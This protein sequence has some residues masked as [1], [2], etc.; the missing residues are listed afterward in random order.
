MKP[1]ELLSDF[2]FGP[3]DVR[4]NL[5]SARMLFQYLADNLYSAD[6]ASGDRVASSDVTTV[7]TWLHELSEAAREMSRNPPGTE[8]QLLQELRTCRRVIKSVEDT[9]PRCGHVH[10]GSS[11]CGMFMGNGRYCRCEMEGVA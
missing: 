4:A 6:L 9:C 11:E 1:S 3:G 7:K 10:E 2:E 5:L 8:V